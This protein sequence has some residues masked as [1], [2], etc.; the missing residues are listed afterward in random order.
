M[1]V[2]ILDMFY[3]SLAIYAT[4]SL[5]PF[6]SRNECTFTFDFT[7]DRLVHKNVLMDPVF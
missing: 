1:K 2:N 7:Q 3:V 5:L 4:N 6:T